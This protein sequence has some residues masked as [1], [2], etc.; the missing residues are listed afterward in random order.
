MT[1]NLLLVGCGKMGSALLG[2]YIAKGRP[3]NSIRII[4][5]NQEL[6]A[7]LRTQ[8]GV[9]V[10]DSIHHLPADYKFDIVQ[11]SVKPQMMADILI[12]YKERCTTNTLF[13]S[14]AAGKNIQ[15]F[16]THLGQDYPIIRA[17]PNLPALVGNGVTALYANPTATVTQKC[18]TEELFSSVGQVFWLEK[19]AL[20][21]PVTAI[22]GSGPAYVF[23]FIEAFEQAALSLGLPTELS[24]ALA[25]STIGG[26]A[27]M[28]LASNHSASALR[29]QVTSPKGTTEAGL[30]VLMKELTSIL[31]RTTQAACNRSKELS[32]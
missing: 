8:Y 32:D 30:S 25:Y 15:F 28:A 11:L 26:S 21:D 2:G 13:I 14:I 20:M 27:K 19:E 7:S 16:E 29:E 5:P 4:E 24:H 10:I 22:S 1:E 3:V 18:I 23:H 17:M 6:A 12:D 9:E 31:E